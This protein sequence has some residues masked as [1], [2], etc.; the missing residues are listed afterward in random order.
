VTRARA[1]RDA[2]PTK[3][4]LLALP[5]AVA[6]T[7][8]AGVRRPTSDWADAARAGR[9]LLAGHLDVFAAMPDVQMGPLSLIL[10]G[11]LP[12][13]AYMTAVCALLP[14]LLYLVSLPYPSTRRTYRRL[15]IGGLLLAWPWAA[16]GV[17]GHGDDAIVMLGVVLMVTS[18]EL[19]RQGGV[20]A[21]FLIA[22]AA[23]P[24]AVLFLPLA[25]LRSR[26]AGVLAMLG[27]AVI[28]APFALANVSG[29]LAAGSGQGDLWPNS[30]IDFLGGD[31]HTGFPGWVRPVQLI[32]GL[33]LCWVLAHRSGAAAA[34]VGVLAFRVL[35][36]PGTWNYYSTALV[37]AG[38]L[39]DMHR[40][41]RVPWATLL[42]FVSFVATFGAPPLSLGQG[43]VR[44]LALVTALGLAVGRKSTQPSPVRDVPRPETVMR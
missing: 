38:L 5:L 24:T 20:V 41:Y 22:I 27:A 35:L 17:Q 13:L 14:L 33:G 19:E 4:W 21:G 23:K 3:V 39:L 36:E 10:V 8:V 37:A 40:G 1:A 25:F 28:W 11:L 15:L 7:L 9:Y 2:R 42:G 32:G 12:G 44:V 26:R 18:L 6:V 34:V 16:Y 43:V 30:L 31:P 29:F